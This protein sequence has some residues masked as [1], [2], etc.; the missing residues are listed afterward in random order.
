MKRLDAA[1][2]GLTSQIKNSCL[3][4]KKPRWINFWEQDDLIAWPVAPIMDSEVVKDINVNIATVNP[5]DA[6]NKY[7]ESADCHKHIGKYWTD[8]GEEKD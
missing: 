1:N 3:D 5:D 2:H 8:V 6:H 7:W 4:P